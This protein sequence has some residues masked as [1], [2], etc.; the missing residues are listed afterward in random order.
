MV[1]FEFNKNDSNDE[2]KK[3]VAM[4]LAALNKI[5]KAKGQELPTFM[6]KKLE[7]IKMKLQMVILGKFLKVTRKEVKIG[8][9]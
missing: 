1:N 3:D 6:H 8:K 9:T 4:G 2:D 7:D 5:K